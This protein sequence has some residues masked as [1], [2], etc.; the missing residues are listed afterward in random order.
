MA[1]KGL[2]GGGTTQDVQQSAATPAP[3]SAPI[4]TPKPASQATVSSGGYSTGGQSLDL[5][6]LLGGLSASN[7]SSGWTQ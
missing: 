4:A 3:V 5:A 7:T 1:G 2:F 6:S